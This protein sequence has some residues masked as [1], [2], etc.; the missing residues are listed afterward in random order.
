MTKIPCKTAVITILKLQHGVVGTLKRLL[1]TYKTCDAKHHMNQKSNVPAISSVVPTGKITRTDN[2]LTNDGC[3]L[4]KMTTIR[5]QSF[6]ADN[7]FSW[8]KRVI[9]EHKWG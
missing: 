9:V 4:L 1:Y 8:K 3:Q 7:L 5:Y 6:A 2:N